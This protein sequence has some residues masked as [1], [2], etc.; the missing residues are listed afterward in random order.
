MTAYKTA[1]LTITLRIYTQIYVCFGTFLNA[2]FIK[3]VYMTPQIIH[4][5]LSNQ[6]NL[7]CEVMY[8]AQKMEII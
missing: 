8:S 4:H 6:N 5:R 1:L 3:R 7:Q 2:Y